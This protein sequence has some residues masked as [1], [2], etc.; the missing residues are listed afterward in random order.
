MLDRTSVRRSLSSSRADIIVVSPND[1]TG[2]AGRS[3]AVE[4]YRAFMVR[5]KIVWFASR[6]HVVTERGDAAI[7]EYRWDRD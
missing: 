6:D 7:V 1:T 3:A 4:N 5:A 2:V